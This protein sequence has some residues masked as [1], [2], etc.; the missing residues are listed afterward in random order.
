VPLVYGPVDSHP[1]KVE[2]K[3]ESY[4]NIKLLIENMPGVTALM[5]DHPVVLQRNLMLQLRFF[6][7]Y[8]MKF[9]EALKLITYNPAR[10]V[11]INAGSV[12]VGRLAS[13]VAWSEDPQIMG[14]YPQL[15]IAEGEIVKS[16]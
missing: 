15:I 10:I 5:S 14:A 3:H 7:R 6:V 4:K 8:G 2:L 16:Q 11:G 9:E 13:L 12:E 1:Y